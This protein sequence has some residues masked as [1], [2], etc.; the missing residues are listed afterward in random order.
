MTV[1]R[2]SSFT[3]AVTFRAD[4]LPTGLTA[5]FAEDSVAGDTAWVMFTADT[6]VAMDTTYAVAL[7][8]SGDSVA[9]VV[10]TVYVTVTTPPN[11]FS[12]TPDVDSVY[13]LPGSSDTLNVTVGRMGAFTG[14]VFVLITGMPDGLSATL[15]VDTV[16][17]DTAHITL[18]ADSTLADGSYDLV[19][20]GSG[21]GVNDFTDTLTVTVSATTA[22]RFGFDVDSLTIMQGDQDTASVVVGPYAGFADTVSLSIDS[23]PTG[24]TATIDTVAGLP[25]SLVVGDTLALDSSSVVVTFWVDSTA[26]ADT[27]IAVV[28]H[29]SSGTYDVVTDTLWL[30]VTAASSGVSGQGLVSLPPRLLPSHGAEASPAERGVARAAP[31]MAFVASERPSVD[32]R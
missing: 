23:L 24:I 5:T 19:V 4:S 8:V 31:R 17:A 7:T 27:P 25:D 11:G 3:G 21:E 18:T 15:D 1:A 22:Y 30:T 20:T 16:A 32:R 9:D 29:G 10:D 2:D 28:V 26:T 12:L 13:M 6:T 14:P